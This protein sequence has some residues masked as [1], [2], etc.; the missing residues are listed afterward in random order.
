MNTCI[1]IIL[2]VV[3]YI[4]SHCFFYKANAM[5]VVVV[6]Y[7]YFNALFTTQDTYDLHQIH[8]ISNT[9]T[10]FIYSTLYK[11]IQ[12][13]LSQSGHYTH[14]KHFELSS[15]SYQSILQEESHSIDLLSLI[16]DK[17]KSFF[18]IFLYSMIGLLHIFKKM[19]SS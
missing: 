15:L 18:F 8:H 17:Y 14:L 1:Q 10:L 2:F 7:P 13:S 6:P 11:V 16:I 9:S 5:I 19:D 4:P 12:Q 3:V